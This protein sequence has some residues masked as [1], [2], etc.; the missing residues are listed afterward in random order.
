MKLFSVEDISKMGTS[1]PFL[2]E[3]QNLPPK[4][5]IDIPAPV[6]Q[7]SVSHAIMREN[8]KLVEEMR[9]QNVLLRSQLDEM[10]L[11]NDEARKTNDNL[12]QA[13]LDLKDELKR[14]KWWG[15]VKTR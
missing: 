7:E 11:A 13:A 15:R 1:N 4:H 14:S 5:N 8:A 6:L 10:R 9:T 12:E 3:I 2:S